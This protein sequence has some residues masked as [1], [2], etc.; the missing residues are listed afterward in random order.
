MPVRLKLDS[1]ADVW[2]VPTRL[3]AHVTVRPTSKR[4]NAPGNMCITVLGEFD[5]V[6][7]VGSRK[8]TERLYVVDKTNALL[9]REACVKLGLI[10]WHVSD[11]VPRTYPQWIISSDRTGRIECSLP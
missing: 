11:V 8:H 4:L 1:G 5:S 2:V 9:G 6:L 7:R 3:C 10:N